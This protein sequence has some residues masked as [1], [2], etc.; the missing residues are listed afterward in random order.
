MPQAPKSLMNYVDMVFE[1]N[2]NGADLYQNPGDGSATNV[3]LPKS[4]KGKAGLEMMIGDEHWYQVQTKL[5]NGWAKG[6]DLIL[7]DLSPAASVPVLPTEAEISSPSDESRQEL[8]YFEAGSD[9]VSYYEKPSKKPK[10]LGTL[11]P[12][13]AY[14]AVNSEKLGVDRWFLLQI[15]S[16]EKGWVQGFELKL[17]NVQ[18]PAKTKRRRTTRHNYCK[19]KSC[20]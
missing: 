17:S 16:D 20:R 8:T 9:N 5:G 11:V 12:D 3:K 15:R 10:K 7:F 4:F 13:T 1:V 6:K 2:E 19:S 14:L 18:Q